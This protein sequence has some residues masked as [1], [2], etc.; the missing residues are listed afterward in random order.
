MPMDERLG[1]ISLH[2]SQV[3]V[4]TTEVSV[5]KNFLVYPIQIRNIAK[6]L[7]RRQSGMA[8]GEDELDTIIIQFW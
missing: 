1:L 3:V 5:L 2:L 8:V 6:K 7:R 4:I